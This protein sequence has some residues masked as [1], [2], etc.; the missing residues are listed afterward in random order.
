ML[1]SKDNASLFASGIL[2]KEMSSWKKSLAFTVYI[3]YVV[4]P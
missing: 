1:F 3:D 4:L 2:Q